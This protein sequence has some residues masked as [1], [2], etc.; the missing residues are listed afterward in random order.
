MEKEN[1]LDGLSGFQILE[2]FDK[3]DELAMQSPGFLELLRESSVYENSQ[4]ET[5]LAEPEDLGFLLEEAL[6]T[7]DHQAY[8]EH[9]QT[10][11]EF[12]SLYEQRQRSYIDQVIYNNTC[13]CGQWDD[14]TH[15]K[16]ECAEVMAAAS[17]IYF[18]RQGE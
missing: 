7:R 16:A 13:I 17:R 5:S 14:D 4:G 3:N 15:T 12:G 10:I 1:K 18:A 8:E 11:K 2:P 9:E 6:R